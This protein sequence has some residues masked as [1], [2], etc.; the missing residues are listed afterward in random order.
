MR[1]GFRNRSAY[2]FLEGAWPFGVVETNLGRRCVS[3]LVEEQYE[4][5]RR[6][7]GLIAG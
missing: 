5:G 3:H 2:G 4:D 1:R 7:C 6:R